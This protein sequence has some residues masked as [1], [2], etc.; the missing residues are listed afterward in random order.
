MESKKVNWSLT[1]I[2]CIIFGALGF[3]AGAMSNCGK[4][5]SCKAPKQSCSAHH[6]GEWSKKKCCSKDKKCK[7]HSKHEK[8]VEVEGIISED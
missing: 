2:F 5:S 1:L 6:G 7:K 8:E 4:S 3:I